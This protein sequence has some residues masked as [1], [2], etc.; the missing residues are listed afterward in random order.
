MSL[1]LNENANYKNNYLKNQNQKEINSKNK[2]IYELQNE[3]N[4]LI[5]NKTNLSTQND[6]YKTLNNIT[7]ISYEPQNSISFQ[8]NVSQNHLLSLIQILQQENN[9]LR[10]KLSQGQNIEDKYSNTIQYKLLSAKNEVENLKRMITTKDNIIM[11]LQNFI[12]N[13]NKI[14]SNGKINLNINQL[15]TKEFIINLK[16]LETKIILSLQKNPKNQRNTKILQPKLSKT[17]NSI[18]KKEKTDQGFLNKKYIH[19]IP[20]RKPIKNI[21]TKKLSFS[22]KSH[23]NTSISTNKPNYSCENTNINNRNECNDIRCGTCRKKSKNNE[24][25]YK[26][27]K[28]LRLKGFLLTKPEGIFSRTPK[29]DHIKCRNNN[30]YQE[31]LKNISKEY[32][33][34]FNDEEISSFLNKK[35]N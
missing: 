21:N 3:L 14:I 27:R 19:K 22:Q 10:N 11:N 32:S 35:I 15:D 1:R 33:N 16:E 30:Y 13:I 5:Q 12:N 31:Y 23:F 17:S 6:T 28:K 8:N 9:L 25:F 18:L 26:E 34:I 2:Q 4:S 7:N 24:K 20:Q 29:K